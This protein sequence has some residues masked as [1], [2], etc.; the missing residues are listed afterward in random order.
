MSEA[1]GAGAPESPWPAFA[2]C[3]ARLAPGIVIAARPGTA[4]SVV[5]NETSGAHVRLDERTAALLRALDGRATVAEHVAALDH[6]A[7][8]DRD[9]LGAALVTL[10]RSGV[11]THG[12]P[13]GDA[14][15]W[16][17]HLAGHR[18]RRRL[19]RQPLMLRAP[20]CDPD[21]ALDRLVRVLRPL[22]AWHAALAVACL[23]AL[24]AATLV[25]H[26]NDAASALGTLAA[27]PQRWWT[28]LVGWPV[29][30]LAHE[31]G[32]A[33]AVRAHGG[34]VH[35]AGI[36][37]LVFMPV[38]YVDASDASLFPA[39]R[40][41]ALVGAAGVMA[42]LSVASLAWLGWCALEPGALADL[43]FA[44]AVAGSVSTLA[45]NANPLMRFD[46]YH[47]LQDL[48][49]MPN[50]SPRASACWRDALRRRVFGVRAP[51]IAA[52]AHTARERRILLGYGLLAWVWRHVVALGIA[53]W[54]VTALPGFVPPA[55]GVALAALALWP[56]AGRPATQL[57]RWLARAPDLAGRR[58]RG[59]ATALVLIGVP[60][61]VLCA[62]PLPSST[63]IAG[64]VAAGDGVEVV[65]GEAGELA[66]LAVM[67]GAHVAAGQL[68]ARL[69][70]PAM[71]T[72]RQ[73][74]AAR[75][76]ELEAARAV[77][78]R[79]DP[80]EARAL[81]AEARTERERETDIAHRQDGLEVRAA[82]AGRFVPHA[83]L[84]VPGRFVRAGDVLGHVVGAADGPNATDRYRLTVRAVLPERAVGRLD[85]GVAEARVRLAERP[86]VALPARLLRTAPAAEHHLPSA[87]LAG[88]PGTGVAPSDEG[89]LRTREPVFHVELALPSEVRVAGLGGR[90]YVTLVHP[91]ET[92]A[93]RLGRGLRQLFL[94][95]IGP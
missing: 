45:F 42:E 58:A 24:C 71:T 94:E 13:G 65:A 95:R 29:L 93:R 37:L 32:H 18:E 87:S 89:A 21:A 90:A 54:L 60:A 66:G 75:T 85:D 12:P 47:V 67:P 52:P 39:R 11:V 38:P 8:M 19:A 64:V 69:R 82:R 26:A 17:A 57:V 77:A 5:R 31:T 23:A 55:V 33:L 34:R 80:V 43:L 72:E 83:S 56:L 61:S 27:S 36:A 50:L 91:S 10:E 35:E 70:A 41:R 44:T 22:Q 40:A 1:A 9:A 4:D 28:L 6:D 86:A 68:V 7:P 30:K 84:A 76:A 92:L 79:T 14:R 49:E 81:A 48:L 62:L 53:A 20:L 59:I 73:R 25:T 2:P 3:R 88:G 63:R 78:W 15:T 46:G 51:G 16:R 74:S